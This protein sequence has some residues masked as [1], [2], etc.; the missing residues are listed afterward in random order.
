VLKIKNTIQNSVFKNRIKNMICAETCRYFFTQSPLMSL[1]IFEVWG[2][3]FVY[4][5]RIPSVPPPET[6]FRQLPYSPDHGDPVHH[7]ITIFSIN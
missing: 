4:P 6:I 7:R 5:R 3:A 1:Y 2:L